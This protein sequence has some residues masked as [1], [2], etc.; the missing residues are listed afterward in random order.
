VVV[1]AR[2]VL[3]ANGGV[4]RWAPLVRRVGEHQL[5]TEVAEG[6]VVRH[7]RGTYALPDVDDARVAATRLK[8]ALSYASAALEVGLDLL[9][10]PDRIHV[11]IRP[12]AMRRWVPPGVRVHYADLSDAEL[13]RGATDVPRT[14]LDCA[15]TLP[16]RE[17]LAITDSAL[18]TSAC[19][20]AQ[21]LHELDG[22]AAR[23]DVR[24]RR[25]VELASPMTESVFESAL[26]AILLDLGLTCFQPQ[27]PVPTAFGRYR[28][29]LADLH[30][31]IVI[32]AESFEFHGR[33]QQ[34]TRD[35]ARTNALVVDGW[36][37][38]RFS[39]EQVLF[40]PEYV[41]AVILAAHGRRVC[42]VPTA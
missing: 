3:L 27:L 22:S 12:N 31:R 8:G 17:A 32:E 40:Q 37:V 15:R 10:A 35:C 5:A 24:A 39:W 4:M 16:A 14:V 21:L 18:R 11:T 9:V 1:L 29:D 6:T 38:L 19:T 2:Q 42:K 30:R 13:A 28:V 23:G 33:R 34:L 20:R 41:K 36:L 26:R 25:V 7:R